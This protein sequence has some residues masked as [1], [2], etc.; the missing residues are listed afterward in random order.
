[1]ASTDTFIRKLQAQREKERKQLESAL[2]EKST[3]N[4]NRMAPIA[5][6]YEA[7]RETM[8]EK[9]SQQTVGLQ[10]LENFRQKRVN[11]LAGIDE[12]EKRDRVPKRSKIRTSN[13]SF[14]LDDP[15]QDDEPEDDADDADSVPR[16]AKRVESTMTPTQLAPARASESERQDSV[17]VSVEAGDERPTRCNVTLPRSSTVADLIDAVKAEAAAQFGAISSDAL[18]LVSNSAIIPADCTLDQLQSCSEKIV[19]EVTST[20]QQVSSVPD[21]N[22]ANVVARVVTRQWYDRQQGL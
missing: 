5:V 13:L 16:T 19:E 20:E 22:Q 18:L 17:Q 21:S 6:K 15:D 7:R 8:Q 1:M 4:A 11:I 9:L 3:Q 14:D 2:A 10:T 12:P